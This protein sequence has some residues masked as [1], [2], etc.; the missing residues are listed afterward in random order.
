MIQIRVFHDEHD[1]STVVVRADGHATE[2]KEGIEH[3]QVCAGVSMLMHTLALYSL[4]GR[5]IGLDG[6]GYAHLRVPRWYHRELAFV[7]NGLLLI[8]Q[9]YP[10]HLAFELE[11]QAAD[12]AAVQAW[13][14]SNLVT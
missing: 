4:D 7:L 3:A 14:E 1:P 2:A 6:D 11:G 9:P 12:E 10:G 5:E 8:A 13:M